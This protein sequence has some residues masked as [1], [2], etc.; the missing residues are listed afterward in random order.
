MRLFTTR[1]NTLPIKQFGGDNKH[2]GG[3]RAPNPILAKYLAAAA[4]LMLWQLC[5]WLVDLPLLLPSPGQ[6]A[7]RLGQLVCT[8]GFWLTVAVTFGRICSGFLLAVAA[9]AVL[10]GLAV[11]SSWV[12]AFLYPFFAVMQA[13]P[14]A[15][16]TILALVW[17]KS[18]NLSV[19]ISFIMVLPMVYHNL[20]AGIQNI[21]KQLLEMGQV[22]R[23]SWWKKVRFLYLPAILPFFVSACTTG[24]GFAWKSGIAAEVLGIPARAI[25]TEIYRAKIYLETTDL[26]AWT[27]VVVSFS[28]ILEKLLVWA[29]RKG[30]RHFLWN[31]EAEE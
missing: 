9:G 14:V 28:V 6:V 10:A 8:K 26:F 12:K 29:I 16:F 30:E 1:D 25:G 2:E 20:L 22:F 4:W 27:V 31:K 11:A 19:F 21:D 15:S 5:Y 24:I 23:L 17:I 7:V 18:A 13:T 3:K